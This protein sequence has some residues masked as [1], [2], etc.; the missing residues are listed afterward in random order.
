MTEKDKKCCEDATCNCENHE[1]HDHECGC[2]CGCG[3]EELEVMQVELEDENGNPIL[4]DVI[5]GF[6]YKDKEY[7]VLLN[8]E[9]ESYY[10]F[11]VEGNEDDDMGELVVPSEEEFNEVKDYY[12]NLLASE[13]EDEEEE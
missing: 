8:P 3:E 11:K 4:C 9:D 6:D 1:E 10:I 13:E 5:D 2:C 12:E 7:A